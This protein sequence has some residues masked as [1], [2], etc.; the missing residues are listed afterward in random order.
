M[1]KHSHIFASIVKLVGSPY[2]LLLLA[3]VLFVAFAALF[4]FE[5]ELNERK[6]QLYDLRTNAEQ[7]LSLDIEATA[8]IRNAAGL[9]SR[10]YITNYDEL[11]ATKSA[12][13]A[14]SMMLTNNEAILSTFDEL[15]EARHAIEEI[16]LE[17]INL[18]REKEWEEVVILVTDKSFKRE[19]GL[20]RAKLSK[21]LRELVFDGEKQAE[22]T[23]KMFNIAQIS[24]LSTFLILTIIGFFYSQ[25]MRR[26]LNHQSTMAANLE[27]ANLNLEQR[28]QERTKELAQT[29]SE[30]EAVLSAIDYGVIFMDADL[31]TRLINQACMEIWGYDK[32]YIDSKPTM[33]DLIYKN[34]YNNIY[35]VSDENFDAYVVERVKKVQAGTIPPTEVERADGRILRYQNIVLPDGGR[36][37]TY[38]DVTDT[39]Q[40]ERNL[41]EKEKHLRAAL[42]NMNGGIIMA[43]S[44]YKILLLNHQYVELHGF[45]DDLIT[46]GRSLKDETLYQAKNGEFGPGDPHELAAQAIESWDNSKQM[47]YER[48]VHTGRTLR[49]SG[50]PMQNG[51][52]TTIVTDITEQKKAATKLQDAFNIIS[53]SIEYSSRIQRSILPDNS[54][55]AAVVASHFIIW[56]PRDVVGGDIYWHGAWGNGCLI[57]LGDCTGHGVPGAFMTLIAI[58]ALERAMSEIDGG[59]VGKLI[60][61]VHQ[62]IQ[63]TLG[64]HYVGGDSDDGIE[65]GA[66]Y[67]VPEEQEMT[68]AGARF[69]LFTNKDGI[70]SSVKGTKAG[71]GYRGIPYTQ[72]YDEQTLEIKPDQQ[73]YMTTDGLV[74]QV[75]GERGR[76]FGKKRFRELLLKI[77]DKP[78]EEQKEAIYQALLNYQGEKLRRD[79][80][81][82]IGFRL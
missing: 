70:L 79:D 28:V 9:A 71:M 80:I 61:R 13:L 53:S 48:M 50:T 21:A 73:F 65:L 15:T 52:Y 45:P 33:A 31:R 38:I 51:G 56:E 58:G 76:M 8:S 49:F 18:I 12:L 82:V 4:Y 66:C 5:Q 55:L 30:Q 77:S 81:A 24:V 69:E 62:Y 11:I 17:A 1:K 32:E 47:D 6:Q 60:S 39:V 37:L 68:F 74:D 64:Q 2:A 63:V 40:A 42:D 43:D 23:A 67:F 22:Q 29:L 34:R 72:E 10:R 57:I 26:S 46:V 27:D 14:E 16:Q 54:I 36:M 44:D 3:P 35:P 41:A 59:E 78:M 25:E 20:Y 19:L 75:G 7:I